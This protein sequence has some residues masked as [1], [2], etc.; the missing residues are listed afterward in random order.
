M[1]LSYEASLDHHFLLELTVRRLTHNAIMYLH[2]FSK[3]RMNLSHDTDHFIS[4]DHPDLQ[5]QDPDFV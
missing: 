1:V 2:M 5:Q 4:R 3:V